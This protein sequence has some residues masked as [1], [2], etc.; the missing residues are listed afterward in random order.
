MASPLAEV[1]FATKIS[2]L[3]SQ[4]LVSKPAVS[5]RQVSGCTQGKT[6]GGGATFYS[7]GL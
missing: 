3:T 6:G 5:T 7:L 4:Q 2:A 1:S